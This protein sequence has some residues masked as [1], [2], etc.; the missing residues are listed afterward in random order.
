MV[1]IKTTVLKDNLEDLLKIYQYA[2]NQ[3]FD[4]FSVSF[5]QNN[6]LKHNPVLYESFDEV[7]YKNNYPVELYFDIDKFEEIFWEIQKMKKF[8]KTKIRFSPKFENK[9]PKKEIDLIKKFFLEY[10]SKDIKEIYEPCRYPFANTI[11]NAEGSVYPCLSCKMG[12]IKEQ[13]LFEII[14]NPKYRCFRKNLKYSKVFSS[15][16]LCPEL[17]VKKT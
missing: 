13:R 5:L 14:N 2:T 12:N 10:N 15:C 16:Q 11:I 1:D 9:N 3:G 6:K 17:N 8:S 4:F 7:F